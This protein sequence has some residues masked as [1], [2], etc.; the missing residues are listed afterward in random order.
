MLDIAG[1]IPGSINHPSNRFWAATSIALFG[2]VIT[3]RVRRKGERQTYRRW[4]DVKVF[5]YNYS[6]DTK[7]TSREKNS[8]LGRDAFPSDGQE[9]CHSCGHVIPHGHDTVIPNV[10][11][12]ARSEDT[13]GE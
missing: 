5:N 8:R 13:G 11:T 7:E 1:C 9:E 3:V 10:G 6:E 2:W 12:S 4:I